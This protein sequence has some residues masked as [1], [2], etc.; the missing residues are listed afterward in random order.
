MTMLSDATVLDDEGNEVLLLSY[1][2][3]PHIDDFGNKEYQYE[4][5]MRD[6]MSRKFGSRERQYTVNNQYRAFC[7]KP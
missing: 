5:Y 2:F 3:F 6:D 7:L 1:K 4:V